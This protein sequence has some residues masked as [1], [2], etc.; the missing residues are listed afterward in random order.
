MTTCPAGSLLRLETGEQANRVW[1]F[2]STVGGVDRVDLGA[3]PV[4]GAVAPFGEPTEVAGV[5]QTVASCV[6]VAPPALPVVGVSELA[7]TGGDPTIALLGAVSVLAGSLLLLLRG[8]RAD[9]RH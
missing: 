3:G 2:R 5:G 7:F 9:G 1:V 4:W 8:M 6:G